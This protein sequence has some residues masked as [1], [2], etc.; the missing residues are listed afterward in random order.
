MS[1]CTDKRCYCFELGKKASVCPN[2][3]NCCVD[4]CERLAHNQGKASDNSTKWRVSHHY[5]GYCC[6]SHH[7]K[8]PNN[9]LQISE[10]DECLIKIGYNK[11]R[12]QCSYESCIELCGFTTSD[13]GIQLLEL[14]AHPYVDN[15]RFGLLEMNGKHYCGKHFLEQTPCFDK[16]KDV[17]SEFKSSMA[18]LSGYKLYKLFHPECENDGTIGLGPA[19]T[20]TF[21]DKCQL[22]VDHKDGNH[23]NNDKSNL[24][25]LCANCHAYKTFV[26][27]DWE[28]KVL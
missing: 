21:V 7:F 4:D 11:G 13:T 27:K 25:T 8:N 23:S 12:P 20:A 2:R 1:K 19:C 6:A 28:N 22:Q 14:T 15:K 16:F 9:D 26:N 24:Q 5:G 3:P 17:D 10:L 18:S